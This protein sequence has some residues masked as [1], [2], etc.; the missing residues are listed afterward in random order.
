MCFLVM[1]ICS[2]PLVVEC[3]TNPMI[4]D[5]Q[6]HLTWPEVEQLV[7]KIVQKIKDSNWQ[8]NSILALSRG[9]FIPAAMI[10][11]KLGV[12]HLAGL[13]VHKN[14]E[15]IRTAGHMVGL[16]D[17]KGQKVLV[18]DDSILTGRLLTDVPAMVRQRGGEPKSCALFSEG[19]CP[20]PDYLVEKCEVTPLFP[21]E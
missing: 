20:D 16:D 15:G 2:H 8:P 3:Y 10:A 12:K 18:V 19:R 1:A 4:N 17:V 13:D 9:G 5:S 21:W 11:E 6:K 7:T 14:S